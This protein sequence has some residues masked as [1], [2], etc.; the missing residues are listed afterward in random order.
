MIDSITIANLLKKLSD[1]HPG[2]TSKFKCC[3]SDGM[4]ES[5]Y[6]ITIHQQPGNLYK[7]TIT[8]QLE[9]GKVL[10]CKYKGFKKSSSE[11]IIDTLLDLINYERR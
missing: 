1:D 2:I 7:G 4:G 9:N 5:I 10:L 6:E 11:D 3:Y 8:F